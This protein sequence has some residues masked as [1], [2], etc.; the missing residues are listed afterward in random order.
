M[1]ITWLDLDSHPGAQSTL[2]PQLEVQGGAGGGQPLPFSP[3]FSLHPCCI[4][5]VLEGGPP[6][7]WLPWAL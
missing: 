4:Q 1:T 5:K 7:L 2:H 6:G 3:S